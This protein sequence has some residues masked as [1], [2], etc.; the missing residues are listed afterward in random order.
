MDVQR[1]ECLCIYVF[2]PFVGGDLFHHHFLEKKKE[3]CI[4]KKKG[5]M[6]FNMKRSRERCG[7]DANKC[8]MTGS[9]TNPWVWP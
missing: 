7:H 4:S 6:D 5:K 2:V 9:A 3:K 8:A 1:L